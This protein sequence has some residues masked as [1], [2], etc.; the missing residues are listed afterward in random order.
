MVSELNEATSSIQSTDLLFEVHG[1]LCRQ[2]STTRRKSNIRIHE[3]SIV[4]ITGKSGTGKTYLA[5]TIIGLRTSTSVNVIFNSRLI[6]SLDSLKSILAYVPQ[7][8]YHFEGLGQLLL[9]APT[10]NYSDKILNL[11][12]ELN[13]NSQ[14]TPEQIANMSFLSELSGGELQRI[15]V[16]RSLLENK[17]LFV[18]D[19][20][21]SGLDRQ[22]TIDFMNLLK[23]FNE[24]TFL[25]IT[26]D[27]IVIQECTHTINLDSGE[28]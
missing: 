3:S 12:K 20:P 21:T 28:T 24:A 8:P 23:T 10:E 19:E 15:A 9:K 6:P 13:L 26:H 5:Q 1:Y 7:R 17:K 2:D 4:A 18:L 11:S 27:P 16:L 14:I 22:N 25:I